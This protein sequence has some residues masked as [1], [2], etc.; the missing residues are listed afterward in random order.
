MEL[1]VD[2]SRGPSGPSGANDANDA[3]D[4]KCVIGWWLENKQTRQNLC[5]CRERA[6]V[7]KGLRLIC[8]LAE[9]TG[10]KVKW[11]STSNGETCVLY[12][13]G[14]NGRVS[15]G[16]WRRTEQRAVS[17]GKRREGRK[18]SG[19]DEEDACRCGSHSVTHPD[20]LALPLPVD[21]KRTTLEGSTQRWVGGEESILQRNGGAS[22]TPGVTILS[23]KF[24]C[25]QFGSDQVE[26]PPTGTGE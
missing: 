4:A 24:R 16:L 8:N 12:C 14:G 1:S 17:R 18:A 25:L 19:T 9:W 7:F 26:Y 5:E 20:V 13:R 3:N 2:R 10:Q 11:Q 6:G 23:A 15:A 21:K 22:S